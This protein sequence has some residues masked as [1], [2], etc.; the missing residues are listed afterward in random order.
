MGIAT[1]M[2]HTAAERRWEAITMFVFGIDDIIGVG[3]LVLS[4]VA[5]GILSLVYFIKGK[6][7]QIANKMSRM[8]DD[9][10]GNDLRD[11]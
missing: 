10:D 1:Y 6:A 5:L 11:Q 7:E 9:N 4:F 8:E 2:N 3:C